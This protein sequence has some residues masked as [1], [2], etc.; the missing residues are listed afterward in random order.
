MA[1]GD[2]LWL[3]TLIKDRNGNQINIY[4]RTLSN[5]AVVIDYVIDTA[6]RRIDFNYQ[7]NRLTWIGQN[8]NGVWAYFV[9]IDYTPVTIQT[10]F[11]GPLTTDPININGA[12]VYLPS[13]ITYPTGAQHRFFYTSYGQA[14]L[15]QKIAPG[16]AGQA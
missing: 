2:N 1:N 8:R 12:Q 3:P 15:I 10:N 16:I 7:N 5:N 13:R 9:R 14:Y 11:E 4:Y 6:G